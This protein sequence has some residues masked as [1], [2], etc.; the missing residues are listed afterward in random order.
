MHQVLTIF[1]TLFPWPSGVACTATSGRNGEILQKICSFS[2]KLHK[3]IQMTKLCIP[4]RKMLSDV[5]FLFG[6]HYA[7]ISHHL[8]NDHQDTH[9]LSWLLE[10]I[11]TPHSSSPTLFLL[12]IM[13]LRTLHSGC[14]SNITSDPSCLLC[15]EKTKQ[16][17]QAA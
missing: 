8:Y 17:S 15:K 6:R 14:H 9:N 16:L 12:E 11:I 4:K 3:L 2:Q 1:T 10:Y 13:F 5:T 7:G